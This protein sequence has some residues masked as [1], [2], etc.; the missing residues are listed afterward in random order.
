M[1]LK[2]H[3]FVISVSR[4]F[5]FQESKKGLGSGQAAGGGEKAGQT[6]REYP[7]IMFKK[8]RR[9]QPVPRNFSVGGSGPLGSTPPR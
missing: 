7:S 2:I 3:P 5:D 8:E 1:V 9:E 6:G 4:P